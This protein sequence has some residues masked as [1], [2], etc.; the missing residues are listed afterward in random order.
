M[1]WILSSDK[2]TVVLYVWIH[3]NLHLN[4]YECINHYALKTLVVAHH[5]LQNMQKKKYKYY[6]YYYY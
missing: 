3:I 1:T 5:F 4:I 2:H 6:L